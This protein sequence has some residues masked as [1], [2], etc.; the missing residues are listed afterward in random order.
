MLQNWS[1][2]HHEEE[3]DFI[4]FL[5]KQQFLR[6]LE[7]P[8]KVNLSKLFKLKHIRHL[9]MS[10]HGIKRLPNSLTSL[11]NLHT[12]KLMY[13]GNLLEMPKDLRV[14]RNLWYLEMDDIYSL[15]C[16][17]RWLG[18]LTCL[19]TLSISLLVRIHPDKYTR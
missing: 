4:F 8:F 1:Y 9:V 3:K 14:M 18:E 17:P 11:Y 5:S 7:L 10:C 16:T 13:S 19:S 6:A 15:L 2:H 12:L